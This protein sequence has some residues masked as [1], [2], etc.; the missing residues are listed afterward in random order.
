VCAVPTSQI[1]NYMIIFFGFPLI[2]TTLTHRYILNTFL[3]RQY[4]LL[5]LYVTARVQRPYL[6]LQIV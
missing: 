2:T 5:R 3:Y 1:C 4:Y 6:M